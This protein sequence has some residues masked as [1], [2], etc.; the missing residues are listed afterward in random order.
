MHQATAVD[1]PAR[2][3]GECEDKGDQ[4]PFGQ[5]GNKDRGGGTVNGVAPTGGGQGQ[6]VEILDVASVRGEL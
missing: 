6:A 5:C 1:P 3:E 4:P 2:G